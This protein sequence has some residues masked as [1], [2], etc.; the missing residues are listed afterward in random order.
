MLIWIL[1][2]NNSLKYQAFKSL[3]SRFSKE[4]PDIE[5]S[6]EIKGKNTL[7][8]NFF[9]FL[10]D[11]QKNPMADIVEIP[12][13]WTAVFSKLG[14]FL[15]LESFCHLVKEENFPVFLRPSMKAE[16]TSRIFSVPF[17]SE[18]RALHYRQDMLKSIGVSAVMEMLDWDE[19]LN[20]CEKVSS[21]NR[22]KDFYPIDNFNPLGADADDILPCVLNRGS[23]GYFSP[24]F[25][26]CEIM[27]DEVVDAIEDYLGL[28]L[29]KYLPVF[30]ENF[31]EAA[32]IQSKLRAMVFSW[33]KPI[34]IGHSEMKVAPFPNI[35]KK[36]NIARSFN[37]SVTCACN[38]SD[39]AGLFLDWILKS[40]EVAIFRKKLGVFPVAE[41]ELKKSIEKDQKIYE[42]LF[43]S[44]VCVP[45]FS[46]YPS[47]EKIF[48]SAIFD[49][50]IEILQRDY[51]RENLLRRL[52]LIKGETDYLLSVY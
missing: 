34:K 45:N 15:E 6:F 8:N 43:A 20:V 35:R 26:Y 16:D 36:N 47:F 5:V 13:Y 31:Y 28:F 30:E 44:A 2:D 1:S 52:A 29:K 51:C 46:V 33:R 41:R 39:L 48:S 9:K 7:W 24:D 3:L 32:F 10:R 49:C 25:G 40:E 17:Y 12:H 4:Y 42:D 22:R 37:L 14:M 19:F 38:E 21:H 50:C 18:I 11:P 23:L 27:K